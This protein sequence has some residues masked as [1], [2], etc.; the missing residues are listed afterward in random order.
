MKDVDRRFEGLRGLIKVYN[1]TPFSEKNQSLQMFVWEVTELRHSV[2]IKWRS[3]DIIYLIISLLNFGYYSNTVIN[4]WLLWFYYKSIQ[5]PM[6]AII[7]LWLVFVRAHC[8]VCICADAQF[9]CFYGNGRD[10]RLMRS[11]DSCYYWKNHECIQRTCVP[12]SRRGDINIHIYSTSAR[13][14]QRLLFSQD[15]NSFRCVWSQIH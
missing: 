4:L 14:C 9:S 7:K 5:K 15:L 6:V 10:I 11:V 3:Q 1:D 2:S 13:Q 8:G 12:T